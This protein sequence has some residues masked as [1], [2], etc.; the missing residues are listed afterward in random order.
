MGYFVCAC[1]SGYH[2]VSQEGMTDDDVITT[3][4]APRQVS[5][6]QLLSIIVDRLLLVAFIVLVVIVTL[7]MSDV[8]QIFYR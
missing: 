3:G 4:G 6:W 2:P 5:D 8:T 7:V 1:G